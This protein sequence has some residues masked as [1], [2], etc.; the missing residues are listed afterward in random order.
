MKLNL[1]K[2]DLIDETDVNNKII[3]TH[4]ESSMN[5]LKHQPQFVDS[6]L[7]NSNSNSNSNDSLS[8]DKTYNI[9][10]LNCDSVGCSTKYDTIIN[11]P[12]SSKNSVYNLDCY[13]GD[14]NDDDEDDEKC[15]N[16]KNL[17]GKKSSKEDSKIFI[18]VSDSV[19]STSSSSSPNGQYSECQP[20]E[21]DDEE[22]VD[23]DEE[24]DE[25]EED[26]EECC[27][28]ENAVDA[29]DKD[30]SN[31][32]EEPESSSSY[33]NLV[34]DD[35]PIVVKCNQKSK[36]FDLGDYPA[37]SSASVSRRL[38]Q[39]NRNL[40][41]SILKQILPELI[42]NEFDEDTWADCE[43]GSDTEEIC[44]CRNY[45]EEEERNASSEDELPSKD[46]DLSGY[47][48]IGSLSDDILQDSTNSESPRIHRKRKLTENRNLFGENM[49]CGETTPGGRK[50]LALENSALSP[51][52]T[53][54]SHL[55]TNPSIFS[56]TSLLMERRTPRSI[57]PTKDNPPPE[58]HDWLLQF[59]RWSHAER[60][61]AVDR[62]I[63]NCEPTQVRHMMKVIE[64]Q[65]QRDFISLL[66]KELALQV[67]SYL[68]PMDL[69]RAAQ[70]CR[71]WRFLCDDNLLWKEKCKEANIVMEQSTDRPK[72]GRAGNMPP[73]SS[74]WKAAFMRQHIIEM[75]WRSRLIRGPKILK[76]HD[77]HVI[78]CLQFCGNRIVSGSDDNTL[79]VWSAISGKCLRTLVGHT[80]G[81]WS[82]QMSGNTIISGSTDRTLKVWNADSGQCTHTLFGHTST[83]RCMHLHANK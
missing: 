4:G 51:N 36:I 20:G 9:R 49:C 3:N 44:T 40:D 82:S 14:H 50:R 52:L 73:I 34:S 41:E 53:P 68:E 19:A 23:E 77:D 69:L 42:D 66:P 18:R 57:I 22:E 30:K 1:S 32:N 67:L 72:R 55:I 16:A 8:S 64:P 75:N 38:S 6:F 24:E 81:V 26:E 47:T 39:N 56:N 15:R 70:T 43:E 48:N 13:D 17:S 25:D 58:L 37:T 54:T 60:I 33:S 83:V 5:H 11:E 21:E 80:G 76:G 63:E 12:S 45:A 59:Q 79:K 7:L 10:V 29:C 46:V 2:H 31:I 35:I 62:L 28:D 71:S 78:T 27:C 65:F 74:P 61:V